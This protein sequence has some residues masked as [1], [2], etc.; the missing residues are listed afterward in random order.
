MGVS[1]LGAVEKAVDRR[2][3]PN[4]EM[5]RDDPTFYFDHGLS[6][7]ECIDWAIETS[8]WML[9]NKVNRDS[10]PEPSVSGVLVSLKAQPEDR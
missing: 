3:S 7:L 10:D 8:G 2:I 1:D 4:D 6:A 9:P 5:Y